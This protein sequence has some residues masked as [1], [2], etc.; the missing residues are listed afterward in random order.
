MEHSKAFTLENGGKIVGLT[1]HRRF[2]PSD[3]AF[4]KNKKSFLKRKVKID[5]P[6]STMTPNLVWGR[7]RDLPMSTENPRLLKLRGYGEVHN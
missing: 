3:H 7:V 4:R 2:L 1:P 6:P 5:G